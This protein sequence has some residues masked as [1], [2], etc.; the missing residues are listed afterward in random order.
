MK[1]VKPN[2]GFLNRLL[3]NEQW[4]V[5]WC[6]WQGFPSALMGSSDSSLFS[7]LRRLTGND[8]VYKWA[9]WTFVAAGFIEQTM[10]FW[11]RLCTHIRHFSVLILETLMHSVTF[12][13]REAP[14]PRTFPFALELYCSCCHTKPFLSL[15]QTELG[16]D[17]DYD[18]TYS[19]TK[20]Y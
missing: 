20:I 3:L 5:F 8:T 11:L 13:F 16:W 19:I 7:A 6:L 17:A 18:W 4:L 10:V 9:S 14:T 15:E 12:L 1:Q 2:D